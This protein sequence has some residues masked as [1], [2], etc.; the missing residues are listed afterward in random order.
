MST[1]RL[2]ANLSESELVCLVRAG[3]PEAFAVLVHR[4]RG[5]VAGMCRRMLGNGPGAED[6]CQ[7][8]ILLAFVNLDRLRRP[9]SFVPWLAGIALNSCRR[10]IR[11]RASGPAA[12]YDGRFPA[13]AEGDPADVVE[14]AELADLV[15]KAVA[16]LPQGQR[17][18]VVLFYLTGLTYAEVAQEL[19]V[20]ISA[21]KARLHKARAALKKKLV[22]EP[23][24]RKMPM[25]TDSKMVKMAVAE[26]ARYAPSDQREW[27]RHMVQ[28]REVD[29]E[30][31]LGIWIG[32]FEATTIALRLEQA[33]LP[34]P[35]TYLFAHRL[36]DASA[37]SVRE[38]RIERLVDDTFYAVVVV[39]V[40][41]RSQEV[42]A[43]PSDALNLALLT[44]STILAGE[45]VIRACESEPT[46]GEPEAPA[47]ALVAEARHR[48]GGP[49]AG[50][51][52]PT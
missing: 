25:E 38:V 39:E 44:G 36:L 16:R 47:S 49:Q 11:A 9:A 28:L 3:Q 26:V 41:G 4:H 37:A 52:A 20:E 15:R 34:R 1:D 35:D 30:R 6:A 45:D 10:S 19:G 31:R 23:E 14:A 8:A 21:V 2:L 32:E 17:D 12:I 29:G 46:P 7:D 27:P 48:M 43:R 13:A 33:E 18:A 42:D 51:A 22:H 50:E 24:E 40:G 5:L